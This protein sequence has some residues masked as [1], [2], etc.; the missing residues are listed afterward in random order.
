LKKKIFYIYVKDRASA[1][2]IQGTKAAY[3]MGEGLVITDG[4]ERVAQFRIE[5]IQGWEAVEKTR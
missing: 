3:V 5:E 4:E 2:E 1:L